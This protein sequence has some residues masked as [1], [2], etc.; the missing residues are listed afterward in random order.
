MSTANG[1][2]DPGCPGCLRCDVRNAFPPVRPYR[3]VQWF[4]PLATFKLM[5]SLGYHAQVETPYVGRPRFVLTGDLRRGTRARLLATTL[6]NGTDPDVVELVPFVPWELFGPC[7]CPL[8]LPTAVG[9][10][11]FTVMLDQSPHSHPCHLQMVL[12]MVAT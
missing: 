10:T 9:D 2:C 1:I 7:A 3:I 8:D 11:L 12:R 4:S 5:G 6:R